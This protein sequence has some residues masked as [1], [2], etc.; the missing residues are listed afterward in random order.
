MALGPGIAFL[1]VADR[2]PRAVAVFLTTFGRVPLFFYLLHFV[3]IHALAVALADLTYGRAGWLFG[4]VP[5]GA[6]DG[7]GYSLPVLCLVWAGVVAVLWPACHWFAGVKR[8]HA[9]GL[10]SYF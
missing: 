5:E 8:R 4:S 2:L 10:M 6:P 7:Y 9:G 1:T 3:L